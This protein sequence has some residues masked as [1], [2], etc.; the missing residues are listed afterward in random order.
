MIQIVNMGA[1]PL[2]VKRQTAFPQSMY[3]V[4]INNEVVTTFLHSRVDGLP[5]CLQKA[6]AAVEKA[7]WEKAA[8]KVLAKMEKEDNETLDVASSDQ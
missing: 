5:V 8:A 2:D 7:K 6:A 1:V 3:E 4:R